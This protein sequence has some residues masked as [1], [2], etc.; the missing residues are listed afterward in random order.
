M[1]K[2]KD[3]S[4]SDEKELIEALVEKLLK[5]TDLKKALE[6][7][8]GA[9]MSLNMKNVKEGYEKTSKNCRR[10][11]KSDWSK[12][13]DSSLR[14]TYLRRK[15]R[16]EPIEDALNEELAKRF[17][18]YNKETKSFGNVSRSETTD[19]SKTGD[20]GLRNVYNKRKKNGRQIEKALNE[21]L[22]K[23]F[24]G[25]DKES[26]SFG[27]L[28]SNN[29]DW[30]KSS[31]KSL[32]VIFT[33][34][35]KKGKPIEDD[36]NEELARRFPNYDKFKRCFCKKTIAKKQ[37]DWKTRKDFH[38]RSAYNYRK[39][40]NLPIE[41][42]LNDELAKRFVT[43]DKETKTFGNCKNIGKRRIKIKKEFVGFNVPL[44]SSITDAN[45]Y[46]LFFF[47]GENNFNLLRGAN[48]PYE[49]CLVDE[50]TGFAV[51]RKKQ[52][53]F[54]NILYVI[55]LKKAKILTESKAGLKTVSYVSNTHDLF[56][57]GENSRLYTVVSR[58]NE[59]KKVVSL[60]FAAETIKADALKKFTS[61]IGKDGH[62]FTCPLIQISDKVDIEK[63]NR[64]IKSLLEVNCQSK[65]AAID[66]D[67]KE[68]KIKEE[69]PVKPQKQ[70]SEKL[71]A[72]VDSVS[73]PIEYKK[74][75]VTIKNRKIIPDGFYNDV[76]VNGERL[77]KGHINTKVELFCDDTILAIH[78]IVENDANYPAKP[79]WLIYDTNL[80]LRLPSIKHAFSKY[81]VQAK[82][83]CVSGD[84]L[85][86][87][88]TNKSSIYL[89]TEQMKKIARN[90][91]FVIG[92]TK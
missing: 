21:E 19:W 85:R 50:Q 49:L 64:L 89:E 84:N 52:D 28:R 59:I 51:V 55:D 9:F 22:A 30:S 69:I 8:L 46:G 1:V 72:A 31:D 62:E 17:P 76:Y 20:D 5:N 34:R 73:V 11:R 82:N 6:F 88:M 90:K 44:F 45:K 80:H 15:K 29:S 60:P 4:L 87:D 54:S 86:I 79:M 13:S 78:G 63:M 26:Q 41:N 25:Y 24:P 35:I 37:I 68:E 57:S 83:I 48:A 43:Y 92:K 16:G 39:K 74:V 27:N 33:S 7:F 42:E 71:A 14:G 53:G 61:I 77:L 3:V 47:D 38:L 81:N 67:N 56:L 10:K 32:R 40:N 75:V 91:R 18:G 2:K 36:L 23:R 58:F 65:G 66:I 70:D 12:S